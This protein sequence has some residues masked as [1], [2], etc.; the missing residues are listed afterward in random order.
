MDSAVAN[1]VIVIVV[2]TFYFKDYKLIGNVS[3]YTR[4]IS[5]MIK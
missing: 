2:F 3:F 4:E 1:L 5:L